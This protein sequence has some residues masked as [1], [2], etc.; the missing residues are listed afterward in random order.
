MAYGNRVASNLGQGV[1]KTS[2][3]HSTLKVSDGEGNFLD[4]FNNKKYSEV[5]HQDYLVDSSDGLVDVAS[6]SSVKSTN[7]AVAPPKALGLYN[8]GECPIEIQIKIPT[9][10]G[11]TPDTLGG[12]AYVNFL[13]MPENFYFLQSPRFLGYDGAASAANG[14]TVTDFLVST[15]ASQKTDMVLKS[16]TAITDTTGTTLNTASNVTN[17]LRVGDVIQIDSE[18]FR[19]DSI[20]DTT[21]CEVTRGYLGSTAATHTM[22]KDIYIYVGNTLH[23]MDVEDDGDTHV[24]TDSSGRYVGHPMKAGSLPR[25]STKVADGIVPGS[26]YIKTY[27]NAYQSLGI[28]NVKSTDSSGLAASTT[29]AINLQTS[30]GTTVN[31]SFTTGTNVNWGGQGGI[32]SVINQAFKT[33]EYDYEVRLVGGDIRFYHLKA[34]YNDY[35]KIIDPS[36]GTTPFGVG[37][38]PADTDI[39]T[40]FRYSRLADDTYYDLE[41][42]LELP[43]MANI[44]Y[45]DGN[46][47]LIR[48]GRVVG[49]I[50]YDTAVINF[51]DT[52]RTEFVIGYKFGSAHAGKMKTD[53]ST[54][55]TITSVSARS[56]NEKINGKLKIVSYS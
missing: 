53:A 32:I 33:G 51:Q 50:N 49:T 55:N 16:G 47:K 14:G 13:L 7:N 3:V 8:S 54:K 35:V 48:A 18:I 2:S 40:K 4:I 12:A 6:Y 30:L 23:N 10:S 24:R 36:S 20:T 25:N 34:I 5:V 22:D 1:S 39:N 45:D 46:G 28:S 31:I 19:V 27:D 42:G 9:W 21:N 17:A 15:Q 37:K 11:A 52:Y 26:Y 56:V 43:N 38:F 41:T 44:I 29:Y